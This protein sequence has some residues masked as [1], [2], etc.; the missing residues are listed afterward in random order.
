MFSGVVQGVGVVGNV[1]AAPWGISCDIQG[2]SLHGLAVGASVCV[3]GVCLTKTGGDGNTAAFDVVEETLTRTT[4]AT[5]AAGTRVNLERALRVGDENGG[6]SVSGHV[7]CTAQILSL[8]ARG[9]ASDVLLGDMPPAYRRYIFSKGF[10]AI[11]GVSLTIGETTADGFYLHLIPETR[12]ATTLGE[13]MAG[14]RVNIECEQTTIATV[15][16]VMRLLANM[17][18]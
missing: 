18:S 17:K 12:R 7:H 3:D 2:D 13:K 9:D 15:D 6:H 8:S 10:V 16:T 5:Y 11:N 4:L 1:R 14:E